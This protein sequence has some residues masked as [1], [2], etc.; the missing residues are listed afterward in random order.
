M[1]KQECKSGC[2]YPA[3]YEIE[4]A[5]ME[6]YLRKQEWKT[7][8]QHHNT[9]KGMLASAGGTSVFGSVRRTVKIHLL[10]HLRYQS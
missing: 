10:H 7:G 5:G 1:K 6:Q 8:I 4:F 2:S 3:A 9:G